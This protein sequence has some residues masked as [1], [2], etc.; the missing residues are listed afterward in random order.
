MASR[1]ILVVDD[2]SPVC[3]L[4]RVT[5]QRAGHQ[6]ECVGDGCQASQSMRQHQYDILITDL[7]MPERDGIELIREARKD[8]P[9]MRIIAISGGGRV[10][11]QQYLQLAKGMGAH[12]LLPKPFL[13]R[14]L[15]A[16][17]D[18]VS[19]DPATQ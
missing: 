17:V 11:G 5:L 12:A 3:E 18:K 14:D 9:Q 16:A 1:S 19:V 7:L 4:M 8:Y 13:P 15:C 6:V 10:G 2:E